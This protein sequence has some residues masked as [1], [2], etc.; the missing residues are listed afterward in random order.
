MGCQQSWTPPEAPTRKGTLVSHHLDVP[1]AREDGRVD[2]CDLYVFDGA[3]PDATVLVMTLN[4]DA[5][6][7]SP[8]AFHPDVVYTFKIDTNGDAV[9]DVSYRIRFGAL[10]TN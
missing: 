5:G 9:E 3:D 8:V 1:A 6:V 7:T 4:P 10:D 2:L